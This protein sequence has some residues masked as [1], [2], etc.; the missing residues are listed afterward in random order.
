VLGCNKTYKGIRIMNIFVELRVDGGVFNK[1]VIM[2]RPPLE[3]DW[4]PST[5]AAKKS[6]NKL[7][8]D[9]EVLS[10]EVVWPN[11]RV[12]DIDLD[13]SIDANSDEAFDIQK[14]VMILNTVW[15]LGKKCG[16]KVALLNS[17]GVKF[18]FT[19]PDFSVD[20]YIV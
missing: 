15:W 11:L 19:A 5:E 9:A 12:M 4:T 1:D 13:R 2:V 16:I 3:S 14:M 10:D 8:L 17:E 6:W 18:K 7:L 20:E